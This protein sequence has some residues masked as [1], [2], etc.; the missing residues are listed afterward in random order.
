MWGQVDWEK[1][2]NGQYASQHGGKPSTIRG[3][4]TPAK[5]NKPKNSVRKT[6]KLRG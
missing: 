5:K 3:S 1:D 4:K 2:Y 6:K